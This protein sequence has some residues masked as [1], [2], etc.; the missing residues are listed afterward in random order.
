[1]DEPMEI[2]GRDEEQVEEDREGGAEI[3]GEN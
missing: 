3:S 1:V 2:E